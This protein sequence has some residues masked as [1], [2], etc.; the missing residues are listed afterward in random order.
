MGCSMPRVKHVS[1]RAPGAAPEWQHFLLQ[2]TVE[3]DVLAGILV[4]EE[5]HL[6]YEVVGDLRAEPLAGV[7]ARGGIAEASVSAAAGQGSMRGI[8]DTHTSSLTSVPRR[9]ILSLARRE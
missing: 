4:G 1:N 7:A 8:Q 5:E 3:G 6:G 2:L 9:R